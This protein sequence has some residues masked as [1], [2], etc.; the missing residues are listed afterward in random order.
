M[1]HTIYG[2]LLFIITL[3]I[4]LIIGMVNTV[5]IKK[6]ELHRIASLSASN[7]TTLLMYEDTFSEQD[8][9]T[10]LERD[11]KGMSS[12]GECRALLLVCDEQQKIIQ[13]KYELEWKQFNGKV[14]QESIIRTLLLEE[15]GDQIETKN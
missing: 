4:I 15:G 9:M 8:V 12:N 5:T 11:V 2:G 10:L 14:K 13:V 7:L 3:F 6:Q 1:K